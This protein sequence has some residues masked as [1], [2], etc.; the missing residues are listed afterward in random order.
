[1]KL[2]N[3]HRGKLSFQNLIGMDKE[4]V[5]LCFLY[6]QPPEDED[7]KV[8]KKYYT[9][10]PNAVCFGVQGGYLPKIAVDL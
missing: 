6:F 9:L 10:L 4:T 8:V 2:I 3:Q 5:A 1:M 7:F